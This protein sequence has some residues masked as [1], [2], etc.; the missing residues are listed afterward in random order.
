MRKRAIIVFIFC[1]VI[2][3]NPNVVLAHPGR[4]VSNGGHAGGGSYRH[5]HH[6]KPAVIRKRHRAA[7]AVCSFYRG[8]RRKRI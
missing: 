1:G 6:G 7:D 2:L 8:I 4:T 3:F 5:S